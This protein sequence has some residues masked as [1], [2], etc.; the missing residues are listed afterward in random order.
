MSLQ[1]FVAQSPAAIEAELSAAG[2]RPFVARQ[3]LHNV[4]SLGLTSFDRM[5]DL[6][7][8]LREDLASRYALR[9]LQEVECREAADGS[10]KLAL[11]LQ[12]G[13]LIECALLAS[14]SRGTACVSSQVGCAMGCLFCASGKRGL[15]RN[16]LPHEMIEQALLV[17]DRLG[18][19]ERLANVTF[20]GIGEP[21]ANFEALAVALERINDAAGMGIGA[22]RITVS[23]CGLTA[24]IRRLAD[25][26]RQFH[27]A[28][29]LHAPTDELRR[30]LVG[31]AAQTPIAEIM[32]AARYYFEK[33][34][35]KVTFEYVL[36]GGLNDAADYAR[37]LVSLLGDFPSMVNL[38][39]LNPVAACPE[40]RAPDPAAVRQFLS[41]LE[42]GGLEAC[43]RR[44][45]GAELDAACGQLR[46]RV[47]DAPGDPD[48]C[49][50][51]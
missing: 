51:H 49:T 22:R 42:Q 23:T 6:P 21:L 5:T 26:G 12:D 10:F 35:R 47:M 43:I 44:R 15:V 14:G 18:D 45:K 7:K 30:R 37:G 25:L 16:L 20:M 4:Y 9:T 28:V 40:L 50:S 27:L 17:R 29:S 13:N 34:T 31:R 24:G 8:R 46:I 11:R 38:I 39:P 3:L 2:Y 33:T 1:P 19:R 48:A 36:I 41:V 32:Q